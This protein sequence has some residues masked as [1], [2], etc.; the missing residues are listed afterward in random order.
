MSYMLTLDCGCSVRVSCD[1]RTRAARTRVLEKR[2]PSC[3]VRKHKV[4]LRL[5]LWDLLPDRGPIAPIQRDWS[6]WA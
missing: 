5:Y 2:G 1:P 6:G 3:P 4:G